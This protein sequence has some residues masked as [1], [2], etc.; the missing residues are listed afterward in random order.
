MVDVALTAEDK[1]AGP[2]HRELYCSGD[3]HRSQAD[4]P[5]QDDQPRYRS[6]SAARILGTSLGGGFLVEI[7]CSKPRVRISRRKSELPTD[8]SSVAFNGRTV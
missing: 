7:A 3:W 1:Q 4:A 2:K 6:R 5:R 8:W